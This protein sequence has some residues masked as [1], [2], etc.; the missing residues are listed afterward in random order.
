MGGP[1]QPTKAT[2]ALARRI[3]ALIERGVRMAD[4]AERCGVDH[5]SLNNWMNWGRSGKEPF[6]AFSSIITAA[7]S[8]G[9]KPRQAG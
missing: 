6:S 4:A 5:A 3:A 9:K 8:K 7:I 2:P 1:G